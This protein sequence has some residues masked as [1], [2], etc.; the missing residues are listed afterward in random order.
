LRVTTT[1]GVSSET[2][3]GSTWASMYNRSFST[4]A[5]WA[6]TR[7]KSMFL[8]PAKTTNA[9]NRPSWVLNWSSFR[10]D[11]PRGADP[12]GRYPPSATSQLVVT[13][14]VSGSVL[15]RM[16]GSP[17]RYFLPRNSSAYPRTNS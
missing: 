16:N 2:M 11:S 1:F 7:V 4:T 5:P 13:L 12:S 10:G 17:A 9:R 15:D 3:R 6:L 8:V 14:R